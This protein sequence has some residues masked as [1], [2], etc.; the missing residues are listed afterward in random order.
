MTAMKDAY[1]KK[2][3][4]HIDWVNKKIQISG[5]I[6][7]FGTS[8]YFKV[9]WNQTNVFKLITEN[10]MQFYLLWRFRKK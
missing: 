5:F 1:P 10:I 9:F 6:R 3:L 8:V 4:N 7:I 2:N